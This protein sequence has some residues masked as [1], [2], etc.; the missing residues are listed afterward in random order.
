MITQNPAQIQDGKSGV[1]PAGTERGRT[2]FGR[3]ACIFPPDVVSSGCKSALPS[4]RLSAWRKR[5]QPLNT[6][7]KFPDTSTRAF[8]ILASGHS[9]HR[10]AA[11]PRSIP[12]SQNEKF[13]SYLVPFSFENRI[14][15][16]NVDFF[17]EGLFT[18]PYSV[19]YLNANGF[20]HSLCR[21]FRAMACHGPW[22]CRS[23]GRKVKVYG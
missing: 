16:G 3:E 22:I 7:L 11:T 4:E 8:P 6:I 14:R 9:T 1:F 18:R 5:R 13:A 12:V 21:R 19:L 2:F 20:D 23:R 15:A 17:A 10:S